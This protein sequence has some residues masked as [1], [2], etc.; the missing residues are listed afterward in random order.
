[1]SPLIFLSTDGALSKGIVSALAPFPIL[2]FT[3]APDALNHL[4]RHTDCRLLVI[5]LDTTP[6]I[7]H[8]I[9]FI[10]SS[11]LRRVELVSIG[12]AAS[13]GALAAEILNWIAA[14][15]RT[16]QS[17]A[18]LAAVTGTLRALLANPG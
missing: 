1:V 15:L 6:D 9:N 16:P 12:S 18:D 5:D 17:P 7:E 13:H 14:T 8:L 10:K 4:L 3:S 2:V 11:P